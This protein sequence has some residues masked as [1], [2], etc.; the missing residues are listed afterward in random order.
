MNNNSRTSRPRLSDRVYADIVVLINKEALLEGERLPSETRLAEQLNV[1]R[2][3]IRETL[4]R[5]SSDGITEARRGAGSFVIRRPSS[6]LASHMPISDLS[7][8]LGTYE[9]RLVLEAEAARLAALRRSEQ[10]MKTILATFDAFKRALRSSRPAHAEDM[11]L[12]F[13]IMSSTSNPSFIAS[14]KGLTQEVKRIMKAGIDISRDRSQ[15]AVDAMIHE[16]QLV[17][18]AI[19]LRDGDGASLAM[20]WHLSEG[21]KRLMP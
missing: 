12:H 5:L 15:A 7:A 20:R 16:H 4:A 2:T 9:V 13:A 10:D 14:Y 17:V 8:I 18:E 1:S 6:R 11:A 3:I 21:R 19:R